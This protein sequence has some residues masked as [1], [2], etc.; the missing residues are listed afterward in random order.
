MMEPNQEHLTLKNEVEELNKLP[1]FVESVCEKAGI[2]IMLVA[3]LNL[4]VEEAVTN[5]I[6]YAYP[7]EEEGL[8]DIDTTYDEK[9]ITFIITDSGFEFDPTEKEDVDTTLGVEERSIG[10]LGIHL[11]KQIMDSVTYERVDEKNVLT[12]RKNLK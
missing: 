5:V 12:L 2:D 8:V 6:L 4:A 10:G 1:A 7:K 9:C 11:V 3:S